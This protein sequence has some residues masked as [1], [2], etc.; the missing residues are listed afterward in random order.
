MADE[1]VKNAFSDAI[2][3]EFAEQ[4][5]SYQELDDSEIRAAFNASCE[6]VGMENMNMILLRLS[7]KQRELLASW[8]NLMFLAGFHNGYKSA[9]LK[10]EK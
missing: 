3:N 9:K 8:G 7:E 10:V 1:F 5:K 6:M 4:E 2:E